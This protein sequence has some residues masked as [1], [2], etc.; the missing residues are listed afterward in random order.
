MSVLLIRLDTVN[1]I[2]YHQG[3]SNSRADR[4]A[5]SSKKKQVP[6][7]HVFRVHQIGQ[8]ISQNALKQLAFVD[9]TAF[10]RIE[11]RRSHDFPAGCRLGLNDLLPDW[12]SRTSMGS[13][14]IHCHI[15]WLNVFTASL[16]CSSWYPLLCDTSFQISH[17]YTLRFP[18]IPHRPC[19]AVLIDDFVRT[20]VWDYDLDLL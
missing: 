10:C 1:S 15:M 7:E 14:R 6:M 2:Y 12:N 11:V 9:A 13:R 16:R 19:T 20:A 8:R 18:R 17:C 5:L 3:I 4:Q